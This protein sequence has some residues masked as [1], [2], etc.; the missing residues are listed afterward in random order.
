MILPPNIVQS[1]K[2]QI[3]ALWGDTVTVTRKQKVGN[4]NKDITMYS[5]VKCHFSQ[6]SQPVLNQTSTVATTTSVFTLY[7]DTGI[8][9]IAGDNLII[10]HK[11][12]AFE[13]IAG[14]PFNRNWSNA[15]KVE[16]KKIS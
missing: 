7:V 14:Q 3:Q 13:G 1:G 12:Q 6:S 2:Q 11:G 5:D 10:S 9:I 8:E 4:V 15:I 16:V